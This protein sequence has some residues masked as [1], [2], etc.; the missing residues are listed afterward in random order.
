MLPFVVCALIYLC[1]LVM[2]LF[3]AGE[4]LSPEDIAQSKQLKRDMK[5]GDD[6]YMN[7]YE[8]ND[9][10]NNDYDNDND[11]ATNE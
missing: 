3:C 10:E 1:V 6:N 8:N 11:N 4:T 9:Y 2:A 7:D 5:V